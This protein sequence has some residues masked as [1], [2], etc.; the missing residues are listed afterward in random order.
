NGRLVALYG[1]NDLVVIDTDEIVMIIPKKQSQDVKKLVE[2]L[3]EE[4]K[5]EYL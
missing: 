5:E 1:V 3:K 2:R 4:K